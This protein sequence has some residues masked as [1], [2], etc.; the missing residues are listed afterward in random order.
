MRNVNE[1]LSDVLFDAGI[2]R[3]F[4]RDMSITTEELGLNSLE[5]VNLSVAIYDEYGV[6]I[7]LLKK[8][9]LSLLDVCS[10]V[11][12]QMMENA[13]VME[14]PAAPAISL[15][16]DSVIEESLDLLTI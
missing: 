5:L 4:T 9:N 12:E 7:K 8:D 10:E 6:K 15:S 13:P 16:F 2:E 14:V 11:N 3:E 1:F